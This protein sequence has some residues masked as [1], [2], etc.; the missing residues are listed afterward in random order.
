MIVPRNRLLFW[1]ALVALPFAVIGA[2]FPS[3]MLLSAGM[4]GGLLLIAL[5]DAILSRK[6]LEGIRITLPAV[7]RMSKDREASFD[8]SIQNPSR[9]RRSL[10]V[11]VDM[12]RSFALADDEILATLPEE[13]E[14]SRLPWKYVPSQRGKH[15]IS[16]I[17]I[18]DQ[19]RLGFWAVRAALPVTAEIRV[20][21]NLLTERKSL[22]HLFLNRGTIGIHRARQIGKG[23]EF[24]KLRE[25]VPGDSYEDVHWKA[26][27]RKG[28]P[29]T[30]V[31]QIERTQEIYVVIDASRLSARQDVL[32]RFLTSALLLGLAAEQQGDLFGVLTFSDKVENFVRAR[33]GKTHYNACRDAIYAL[34]PRQVNPAFDEMCTFIRLN[35]RR[36]AMIVVLT[37][38]DDPV[39][40]ENFEHQVE[41]IAR[42]HVLLV[43]MVQ[44]RGAVPLFTS[45]TTETI[46]DIYEQLGGHLRWHDLREVGKRLQRRG[47]GFAVLE[48]EQ[49]GTEVV[50]QYLEMKQRQLL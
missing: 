27:A 32:E 28:H 45:K 6:S 49:L 21:P 47:V 9:R 25:Y 23:R 35:L 7:I 44:P 22:G 30:K 3:A 26:T 34:T 16:H 1:F 48:N 13:H 29:I 46:D 42:Q 41:L 12:P 10:R 8:L 18:E 43:N 11:A 5:V 31:F 4:I 24:E 17:Y 33:N 39:I 38:L 20:Y 14:W 50:S 19:S 37:A 2:A 36:R 15:Q 40:A